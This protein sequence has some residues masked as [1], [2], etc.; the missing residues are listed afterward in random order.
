MSSSARLSAATTQL[1][2]P[3]Q[4][5]YGALAARERRGVAFAAWT[6]ALAALWLLAV[7]P[8][9]RTLREAPAR[10][11]ELDRQLQ[12]MQAMAADARALRAL[13]AVPR[14]QALAALRAATERLQGAT[15]AEQGERVVLTLSACSAQQLRE[16]LAEVRATARARAIDVNL[17]RDDNGL[18]GTV[19]VMLAAGATP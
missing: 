19:V 15:L 6:V 11:A 5:W 13:P 10:I 16:W 8:A 1:L 17:T 3:L 7:Q 2:Q 9:W 18:S 14:A 4:R 12:A